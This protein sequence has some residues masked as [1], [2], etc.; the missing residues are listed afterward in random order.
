MATGYR[1]LTECRW[2]RTVDHQL[3]PVERIVAGGLAEFEGARLCRA[4]SAALWV[5]TRLRDADLSRQDADGI[6]AI[7]QGVS[8]F[9]EELLALRDLF[10]RASVALYLAQN[11]V[12]RLTKLRDAADAAEDARRDPT[13][14]RDRSRSRS[15][16]RQD[17]LGR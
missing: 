11:E 1:P 3:A 12:D 6:E 8:Q 13:R 9:T 5:F 14:S 2:C 10:H 4:C 7:C 17:P 15:P 16:R